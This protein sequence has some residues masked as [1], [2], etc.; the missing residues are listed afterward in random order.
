MARNPTQ[1]TVDEVVHWLQQLGFPHLEDLVRYHCL[2]GSDLLQ[3]GDADLRFDFKLKQVH[4]RKHLLR[5]IEQ[6][7]SQS[8]AML[9]VEY[10]REISTLR[11]QDIHSYSF[12]QLRED[13]AKA[14]GLRHHRVLLQDTR[15]S[16]WAGPSVSCLFDHALV[17]HEPV[18]LVDHLSE[19][20]SLSDFDSLLQEERSL[21]DGQSL[22]RVHTITNGLLQLTLGLEDFG[23]ELAQAHTCI[24]HE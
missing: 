21:A 9:A 10:K 6:L 1:W 4:E 12:Q 11:V 7:K 24:P 15:G 23:K 2:D 13:A 8:A 19:E 14:F 18:F 3:L 17:Q 20:E 22:I 5:S 16:V